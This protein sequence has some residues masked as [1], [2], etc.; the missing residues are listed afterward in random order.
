MMKIQNIKPCEM[1][2]KHPSLRYIYL[3][4]SMEINDLN[5]YIKILKSS[6]LNTKQK[7]ANY[8]YET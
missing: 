7:V 8:I 1:Q 3:K 4:T 2:L 6:K 5:I